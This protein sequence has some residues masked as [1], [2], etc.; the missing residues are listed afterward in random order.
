MFDKIVKAESKQT[1]NMLV[2]GNPGTGKTYLAGSAAAAGLKV[3]VLDSDKG[4]MT[5]RA[6]G[7]DVLPIASFDALIE[8]VDWLREG[9][10]R[11]YDLIVLDNLTESQK[12]HVEELKRLHGK[13]FGLHSWG[14]VM[15]GSRHV[16]KAMRDMPTHSL[17]ITHAKEVADEQAGRQVIRIRPALHGSTL[18]HEVGGFFDLVAYA[19]TFSSTGKEVEYRLGFTATTDRHI[20]KDRSGTLSMVEPNDWQTIA[21]KVLGNVGKLHSADEVARSLRVIND[22]YNKALEDALPERVRE[23]QAK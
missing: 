7:A 12:Q 11:G 3:L 8:A 21:G 16:I 2:Y 9:Q 22:N 10:G 6:T 13:R 19:H 15:E 1:I 17:V 18:P 5:I 4:T 23:K 20:C 14:R